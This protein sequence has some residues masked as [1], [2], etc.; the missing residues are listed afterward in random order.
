MITYRCY[1]CG[2]VIKNIY[3]VKVERCSTDDPKRLIAVAYT[4]L[5]EDCYK[6]AHDATMGSWEEKGYR[7]KER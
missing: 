7:W 3:T 1:A 5:C 4:R 6:D 2:K